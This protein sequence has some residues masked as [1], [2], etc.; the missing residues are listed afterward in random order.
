M[1]PHTQGEER[2]YI[3][4]NHVDVEFIRAKLT[5]IDVGASYGSELVREMETQPELWRRLARI[6]RTS[7][8]A[9]LPLPLSGLRQLVAG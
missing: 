6:R 8:G 5:C 3:P 2:L 7:E 9:P 1:Q 4:R